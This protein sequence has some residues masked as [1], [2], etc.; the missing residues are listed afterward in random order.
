MPLLSL[1][2]SQLLP[3]TA[4]DHLSPFRHPRLPLAP[5]SEDFGL[6]DR[7]ITFPTFCCLAGIMVSNYSS[8]IP[9]PRMDAFLFPKE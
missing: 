3:F 1:T 9:G 6:C 7:K 8:I 2:G 4:G 5:T